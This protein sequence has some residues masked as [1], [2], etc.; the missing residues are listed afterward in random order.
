MTR[1]PTLED[2]LREAMT[3]RLMDVHVALPARVEEYNAAEQWVN[4]KPLLKRS[5]TTIDGEEISESLP[6]VPKIPVM[7]PRAGGFF[8]SLPIAKG[9]FVLLVFNERSIDA[10]TAKAGE[11]VDP[12]DARMHSLSDAV[13]FPCFYPFSK[14]LKDAHASNLVVGKD[15][16]IQTHYKSTEIALGE[17]NPIEKL[18]L[19]TVFR[20]QQASMHTS[21]KSQ[22][23]A[24]A[25]AWTAIA[26]LLTA[27]ASELAPTGPFGTLYPNTAA[28][29]IGM[30]GAM[31]TVA[32]TSTAKQT[33]VQTFDTAASANQDFQSNKVKTAR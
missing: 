33:A 9:D 6:I 8:L 1:S 15:G 19:G 16:G 3:A 17:E 18:L 22:F 26:A 7:F 20:A 5:F 28:L 4:A 21:L 13:A 32:G 10:W 29:I 14:S 12:V 27:A 11:E 23:T 2:V 30:A 25:V 31:A 24:E